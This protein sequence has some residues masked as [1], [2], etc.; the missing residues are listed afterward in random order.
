[1]EMP[2]PLYFLIVTLIS[3]S[4][5]KTMCVIL[6]KTLTNWSRSRGSDQICESLQIPSQEE[7][8]KA[9]TGTGCVYC[10]HQRER[11][12]AGDKKEDGIRIGQFIRGLK[13]K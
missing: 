9:P 10:E 8:G 12:K 2:I 1:M 11:E 3:S 6:G 5:S 13:N 4:V 7:Q